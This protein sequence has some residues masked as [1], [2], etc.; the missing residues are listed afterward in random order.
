MQHV[1]FCVWLL[2]LLHWSQY[3]K[4]TTLGEINQTHV[5]GSMVCLLLVNSLCPDAKSDGR[6][7]NWTLIKRK[8]PGKDVL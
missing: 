6:D 3:Q 2:K 1:I 8:G 5:R 4:T 7:H